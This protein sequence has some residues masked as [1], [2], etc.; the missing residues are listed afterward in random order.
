MPG[1]GPF[2]VGIAPNAPH[3]LVSKKTLEV[4]SLRH[5]GTGLERLRRTTSLPSPTSYTFCCF[6][7]LVKSTSTFTIVFAFDDGGGIN[8]HQLG[9][10]SD[11]LSFGIWEAGVF[12]N[13]TTLTV[14]VWYFVAVTFDGTNTKV[15][16]ANQDT[17]AALAVSSH[18]QSAGS[19][20]ITATQLLLGTAGDGLLTE[21]IN[22]RTV[23]ARLWD[24]ALSSD[25]LQQERTSFTAIRT[26]NLNTSLLRSGWPADKLKNWLGSGADWTAPAAGQWVEEEA[27]LLTIATLLGGDEDYWGFGIPTVPRAPWTTGKL[28]LPDPD[29]V[30]LA[31]TAVQDEDFSVPG[32][33]TPPHPVT[34]FT[35]PHPNSQGPPSRTQLSFGLLYLPDPNDPVFGGFGLLSVQTATLVAAASAAILTPAFDVPAGTGLVA[36]VS[37]GSNFSVA[38]TPTTVSGAGLTWTQQLTLASGSFR[39][40]EIWTAP[41]PAGFVAQQITCTP[42]NIGTGIGSIAFAVYAFSNWP[43]LLGA[44][45]SRL[46]TNS[47]ID[48]TVN[49]LAAGSF[50][51]GGLTPQTGSA[52]TALANTT[53]DVEVDD[54]GSITSVA[55][56]HSTAPT[57]AAGNITIGSSTT[58]TSVR[59]LAV[60]ILA[61]ATYAVDE[62]FWALGPPFAVPATLG[63]LYQPDPEEIPSG[64]LFGE[65]DEDFWA[66]LSPPWPV[67]QLTAAVAI[68]QWAAEQNDPAGALFGQPDEDFWRLAFPP[69][70]KPLTEFSKLYL[71]DPEE[72]PAG[73]LF[74]QADEDFWALGSPPFP[75]SLTFSKLYQPDPEEIPAGVLFGEPDDDFWA[76]GPPFAVPASFGKLLLP[77]PEEVAVVVVVQP[78]EDYW[79]QGPPFAVPLTFSKLY[80]S[81]PEEIPAG[82][83]FGQ[84]DEDLWRLG[85]LPWPQPLLSFSKLYLPDPEEIPAGVLFGQPDEDFYLPALLAAPWPQVQPSAWVAV[86]QWLAEQNDPSGALFGEP[87]EDF[88]RLGTPPFAVQLTFKPLYLPDPEEIPAGVLFGQPDE[89]LSVPGLWAPPWPVQA[90]TNPLSIPQWAAEQ[91]DPAG[92]LFGQPDEDFWSWALLPRPVPLTFGKLYLT[93]PEEIPAGSLFGEPDEDFYV[94]SLWAPPW[95]VARVISPLAIGQWAAEQN[96]PAGSLFGE[97]D[98]DFWRLGPP[99]PVPATLFQRLPYLPD[100]EELPTLFGQPDEDF[101]RNWV[102][103]VVATFFQRLPLLPDLDEL[104][105]N[106]FGQPDEDFWRLAFPPYA[107][108]RTFRALYLPDPEEIPA[109]TLFGEPDEDFWALGLPPFA[110][111][112]ALG[113]LYLPDPEELPTLFGQP[114]EDFWALGPPF[115]V[116]ASTN[117]LAIPQWASETNE[118]AGSLTGEPDED[119]WALGPPFAKLWPTFF[120]LPYLPDPEE[121]PA[122]ALFGQPDEDFWALGPPYARPRTF[123]PLYQ[124]DP[125]ELPVG[126]FHGQYDED[127]WALGP[128]YSKPLTFKP[129]YLTD[130]EEVAVQDI[131]IGYLIGTLPVATSV[132]TGNTVV[133]ALSGVLPVATSVMTG[134]TTVGSFNATLPVATSAMTGY[135]GRRPLPGRPVIAVGVR[136]LVRITTG[137][138]A[139]VKVG[140]KVV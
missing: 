111:P 70:A 59:S 112:A 137:V 108:P 115:A 82:V 36:V 79:Q 32:M 10:D 90:L 29:D 114:D 69:A 1:G 54:A 28:Y 77:D 131:I 16:W 84:P 21:A 85:S 139:D 135:F 101:W 122:G 60:E 134:N 133:G 65:P 2:G 63:R 18:A 106:L 24:R 27:P 39:G 20:T 130:P 99:A 11:G 44:N 98:E 80:L 35:Q 49:A 140:I 64:A 138:V 37:T 53:I 123:A 26:A 22:G 74:G 50:I 127:F 9:S 103:P 104:P 3:A 17:G 23:G 6:M 71:P 89:D 97:P 73:T 118:P 81:D 92:A 75:V 33:W 40:I 110:V 117:A 87:D 132:M 78:D 124:P 96:D 34:R 109:G 51:V 119:F 72:V 14:G 129:L 52:N 5:F 100:P 38:L 43:I 19:K 30:A 42:S 31:V 13:A 8:A 48:V 88:W 46:N 102:S 62:D 136:A 61:P 126:F 105:G 58:N 125:E 93:D 55:S 56:I 128:P 12:T 7:K 95:P 120:A 116:A 83:L 107:V 41:A 15:Y 45:G 67:Q 86:T 94:P 113:K 57:A 68:P 121:I 91:N 76:L 47:N 25:E 66:L 4:S